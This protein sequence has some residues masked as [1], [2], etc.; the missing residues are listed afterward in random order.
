M[1]ILI[2]S[3]LFNTTFSRSITYSGNRE[4]VLRT[5]F[6]DLYGGTESLPEVP[7]GAQRRI[8]MAPQRRRQTFRPW[9]V[10]TTHLNRQ[11]IPSRFY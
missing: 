4:D 5:I 10:Y 9:Y 3:T 1:V 2:V 11:R 7:L 8:A 6:A